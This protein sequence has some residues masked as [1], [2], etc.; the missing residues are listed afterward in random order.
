MFDISVTS[1]LEVLRRCV[2]DRSRSNSRRG[3]SPFSF[4]SFKI[5][6]TAAVAHRGPPSAS[7]AVAAAAFAG[8]G[9]SSSLRMSSQGGPVLTTSL[10]R[11]NLPSQASC[12]SSSNSLQGHPGGG[13]A[14]G[15]G[16]PG[17]FS[18]TSAA[19]AAAA[20]AAG[21]PL[22]SRS[23]LNDSEFPSLRGPSPSPRP[24]SSTGAPSPSF[25]QATTSGGYGLPTGHHGMYGK[26]PLGIAASIGQ[27]RA[28]YGEF[29]SWGRSK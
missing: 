4:P 16:A 17:G 5:F 14:P 28:P 25:S 24:Q 22:H 1:R 20:A 7:A 2:E 26:D 6:T 11:H 18:L 9:A 23:I 3:F 15:P 10:S 21:Y 13:G 8:F 29:A 19:A 27:H 12:F